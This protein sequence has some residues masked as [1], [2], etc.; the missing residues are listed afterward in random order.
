MF[1]GCKI[2][3]FIPDYEMAS[4]RVLA[5]FGVKLTDM[6]FSCC[7]YPMR[8]LYYFSHLLG[9]A[10]A[11]AQAEERGLDL[12]TPCKCCFGSFKRAIH[13]LDIDP[14]ARARVQAELASQGLNYTGKAKIR[15]LLEV[16]YHD[17]GV[18]A[19][20]SKVVMPLT[21]LKVAGLHGCHAYRPSKITKFDDP[22]NPVII[23]GLINVTGA[24]SVYWA[25]R[26]SCCGAPLNRFDPEVSMAMIRDRLHEVV[27]AD[28]HLLCVSCSYSRLQTDRAHD[29]ATPEDD[30]YLAGSVLYPQLLGL[31]MGISPAEL[32]L[33][34]GHPQAR[35]QHFELWRKHLPQEI[36]SAA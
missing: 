36:A 25:G 13:R 16:L 18:D 15:H 5:E 14:D 3:Y 27:K 29:A 30:G 34:Q 20:S 7:G 24:Q 9:A 4:R 17:I 31:S 32:G 2:P 11:L 8:H 1:L 10:K 28:A 23:D 6:E 12:V 21:G 33:G 26:F 35:P 22:Y 19:I